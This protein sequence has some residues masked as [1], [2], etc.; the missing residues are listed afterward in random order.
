MHIRLKVHAAALFVCLLLPAA[1]SANAAAD[2]YGKTKMRFIVGA[3]AG[4]GYDLYSRIFCQYFARHVPGKPTIVITDMPGAGGRLEAN[5]LFNVAARDGSVISMPLPSTLIAQTLTP[6][7]VKYD[8]GKFG[9][10]GTIS[11]MTDVLGV[12]ANAGVSTIEQAKQ[13]S[14]V[15]GSTSK[16]SQTN[17]QP[18]L[19]NA[20]LGTK[21]KIVDG[22]KSMHS[23]LL[24]QERGEIQGH[25]D[26]W[27]SW[28][29]QKPK[30]IKEGKIKFLIQ[31]GPKVARL[32]NVPGFGDLVKTAEQ[33][34]LVDFVGLMQVV[35][36]SVATP[37]GVP[38]DRISILR[39]A[40]DETMKD[41]DFIHAMK[42]RQLRL[43]PRTGAS[44][45]A[46]LN[47]ILASQH[48]TAAAL[49]AALKIK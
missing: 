23:I 9:W 44:L 19:V 3:G 4:G 1:A 48:D 37:P 29:T 42:E 27:S 47:R 18:A 17:F 28:L 34:R 20:F 6:N 2:F 10:V 5:Y 25:T 32:P 43:L 21:F 30:A 22:Y 16:F 49:K 14:V 38:P 33:R 31:F 39:K 7:K 46:K 45:E 12:G 41:P 26:P 24:A 40:F 15:I 35:G 11:T 13:K 36:R 8:F